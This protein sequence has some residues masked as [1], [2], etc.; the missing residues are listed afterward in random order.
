MLNVK[1]TNNCSLHFP[2]SP[3]SSVKHKIRRTPFCISPHD[4]RRY[5]FSTHGIVPRSSQNCPTF[6]DEKTIVL[7]S[8]H[9]KLTPT[10]SKKQ[11]GDK[12]DGKRIELLPPKRK[13]R[14]TRLRGCGTCFYEVHSWSILTGYFD[15]HSLPQQQISL[16]R[17]LV[18]AHCHHNFF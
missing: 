2:S 4:D 11:E 1:G 7:A 13:M 17:L 3:S 12:N 14:E 6:D 16:A 8:N 10:S 5:A 18:S 15:W 9:S